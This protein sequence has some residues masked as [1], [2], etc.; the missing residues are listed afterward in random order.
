MVDSS[1][2]SNRTC[3]IGMPYARTSLFIH[4]STDVTNL[5]HSSSDDEVTKQSSTMI[6]PTCSGVLTSIEAL[7]RGE[8]SKGRKR[9]REA[10]RYASSTPEQIQARRERVRARRQNM[11]SKEKEDVPECEDSLIC[12]K[13]LSLQCDYP[14]ILMLLYTSDIF[15]CTI[16]VP[17]GYECLLE[18]KNQRDHTPLVQVSGVEVYGALRG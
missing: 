1:N 10:I 3:P 7:E 4:E 11:T 12:E 13:V 6:F 18:M 16:T 2:K 17:S 14:C 8:S 5:S 15:M 9:P